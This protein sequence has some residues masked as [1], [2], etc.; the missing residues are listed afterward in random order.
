ML[1]LMK[2]RATLAIVKPFA[3][4]LEMMI[5]AWNAAWPGS[6]EGACSL[7]V[8]GYVIEICLKTE[9]EPLFQRM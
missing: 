8:S 7:E 4:S 3:T 1:P 2:S 6:K 9:E 5:K